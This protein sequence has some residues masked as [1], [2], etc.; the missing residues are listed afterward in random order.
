M[1]SVLTPFENIHF[2]SKINT[3]LGFT[4]T[5]YS[6]GTHIAEKPVMITTTDKVHMKCDCVDGSIVIGI[7]EHFLFS[8]ILSAPL[9]YI[10][11]KEPNT[12]LY[13]KV[14]K[15]MFDSI[16]FFFEDSNHNPV[17]FNTETLIFTIQIVKV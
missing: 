10:I 11:I 14:N 2:N 7:R 13:K 8:F 12:I 1:K 17:D 15:T 16:Q 4:N 9:G 6:E 5:D 3:I